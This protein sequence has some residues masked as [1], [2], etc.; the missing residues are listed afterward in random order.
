VEGLPAPSVDAMLTPFLESV[1]KRHAALSMVLADGVQMPTGD[2]PL[3]S[4]QAGTI[5]RERM[6]KTRFFTLPAGAYVVS[7]LYLND[8]SVF[9]EQLGHDISREA[10]WNRAVAAGADRRLCEVLWTKRDFCE[11]CVAPLLSTR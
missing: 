8:K 11:A 3:G 6:T 10:A 4:C 2:F 9:A 7:N 1:R 5:I